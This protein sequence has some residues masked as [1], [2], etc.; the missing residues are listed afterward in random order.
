[1]TRLVFGHDETV[2]EWALK[3]DPDGLAYHNASWVVGVVDAQGALHGAVS[4][5]QTSPSGV[6]IGLECDRVIT[7]GSIRDL[8][9]FVFE[10]L[11]ASR[12]E[13]VTKRTNKVIK[14]HAPKVLGF[15]FEGVRRDWYGPGEDALAYYMTPDTCKWINTDGIFRAQAA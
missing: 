6:T 9:A 2:L 3:R 5:V 7:K 14:K 12:C 10:H 8:F 1:M 15:K 11:G 13:M 4:V